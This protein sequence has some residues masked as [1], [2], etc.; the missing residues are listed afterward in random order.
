MDSMET[1]LKSLEQYHADETAGLL[2]RLPV[3]LGEKFGEYN[4]IPPVTDM[5]RKQKLFCMGG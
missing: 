2:L 5:C 1:A 3:P 4:I